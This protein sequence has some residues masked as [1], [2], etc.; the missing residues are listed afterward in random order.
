M[1]QTKIIAIDGDQVLFAFADHWHAVAERILCRTLFQQEAAFSLARRFGL[2]PQ[3]TAQVWEQFHLDGEWGKIPL[4]PI[5]AD[6]VRA[7]LRNQWDVWVVSS[8]PTS[9]VEDRRQFLAR[10][11]PE[12]TF[13]QAES[14]DPRRRNGAPSKE[15]TLRYPGIQ[16][17]ADDRWPHIA[18]AIRAKVPK[19]CRIMGGHDGDGTPVPG[20]AEHP[21]LLSALRAARI[22]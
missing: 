13:L 14:L 16:F 7:L 11:L 9:G 12:V 1:N 19:V 18:E 22:L 8:V 21:D 6:A 17:Y 3:E 4:I 20:I 2:S 15:E 10:N 5:A